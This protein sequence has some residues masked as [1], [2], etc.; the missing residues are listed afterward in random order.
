MPDGWVQS[1]VLLAITMCLQATYSLLCL[2]FLP[3]SSFENETIGIR[4]LRAP[5]MCILSLIPASTQQMSMVSLTHSP[6][7]NHSIPQTWPGAPGYEVPS[8]NHYS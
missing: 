7:D 8:R 5:S 4:L 6:H 3:V 2:S 1:L